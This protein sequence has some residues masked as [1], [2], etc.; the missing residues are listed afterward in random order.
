MG[1]DLVLASAA[2][3]ACEDAPLSDREGLARAAHDAQPV[4]DGRAG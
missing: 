1:R 3:S 2:G 4:A